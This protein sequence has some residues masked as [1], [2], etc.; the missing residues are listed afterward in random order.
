MVKSKI[1]RRVLIIIVLILIVIGIGYCISMPA[2]ITEY[3]RSFYANGVDLT[4]KQV[5]RSYGLNTDLVSVII[6]Y[7]IS[8][9]GRYIFQSRQTN[10]RNSDSDL[11]SWEHIITEEDIPFSSSRSVW[12][13]EN[14]RCRVEITR[15]PSGSSLSTSDSIDF[16]GAMYGDSGFTRIKKQKVQ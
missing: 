7:K 16:R 5:Y 9:P 15:I 8:Q 13:N 4:V 6:E 3:H 12:F 10:Y 14:Q 1:I 2:S 11:G